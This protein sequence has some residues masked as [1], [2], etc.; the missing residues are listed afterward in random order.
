MILHINTT[1]GDDIEIIL[2]KNDFLVKKKINARYSQA[3]KLL[4][5][6]D[7][8]LRENKVSLKD[9][10]KVQMNNIGGGF[11]ALRIG[12][13]TANATGYALNVPVE[14]EV[15]SRKLEAG[16]KKFNIIEPMYNRGPNIT[17]KK[18]KQ[19]L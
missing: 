18:K 14:G 9:I 11:T 15:K 17:V 3:E 19:S 12:V 2:K 7:K 1:N 6:V 10:E 16:S 13:V 4:S 5:L 8:I